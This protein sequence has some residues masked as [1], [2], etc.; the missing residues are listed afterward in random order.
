MVEQCVMSVRDNAK[1]ASGN[2]QEQIKLH[3]KETYNEL[4]GTKILKLSM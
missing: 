3:V 1:S 2:L 4:N